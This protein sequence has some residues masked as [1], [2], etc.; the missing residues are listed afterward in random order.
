MSTPPDRARV[1]EP[2]PRA[3]VNF[4]HVF[5]EDGS[6]AVADDMSPT[7]RA[8]AFLVE[9]ANR[10]KAANLQ[11]CTCAECEGVRGRIRVKRTAHPGVMIITLAP[12]AP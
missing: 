10:Q 3:R 12:L 8:L 11:A 5:A 6:P 9:H 2:A 7:A 1:D 4:A